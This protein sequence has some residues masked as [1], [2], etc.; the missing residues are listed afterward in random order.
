MQSDS[1]FP[2]S[3]SSLFRD[4]VRVCKGCYDRILSLRT[5]QAS[6]LVNTLSEEPGTAPLT[7][8]Q[9][10]GAEERAS[11]SSFPGGVTLS[12]NSLFLDNSDESLLAHLKDLVRKGS[13]HHS[14]LGNSVEYLV[15]PLH[16]NDSQA[17]TY[18]MTATDTTAVDPDDE[19]CV[20]ETMPKSEVFP[21]GLDSPGDPHLDV[22]AL[23]VKLS[24]LE[25]DASL[26]EKMVGSKRD[27]GISSNGSSSTLTSPA[28]SIVGEVNDLEV[29]GG[30][31]HNVSVTVATP[32]TGVIWQFNSQPKGIA[33][34]LKYQETEDTDVS[35][36]VN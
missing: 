27:G 32:R 29:G 3:L 11:I 21:I 30:V 23:R 22:H 7:S 36:E 35:V 33:I 6:S 1:S 2:D 24:R 8:E 25:S 34:G 13:S 15:E 20:I 19:F 17:L 12:N 18:T 5:P 14:S 31:I 4:P 9:P 26:S 28:D 16:K 10:V